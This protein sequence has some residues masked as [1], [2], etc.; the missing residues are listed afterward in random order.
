VVVGIVFGG[1]V[2][3]V[4]YIDELRRGHSRGRTCDIVVG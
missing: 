4:R 3:V 2:V 1:V